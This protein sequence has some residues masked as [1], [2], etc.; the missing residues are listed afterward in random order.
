[1]GAKISFEE[2]QDYF[3]YNDK[4]YSVRRSGIY[5]NMWYIYQYAVYINSDLAYTFTIYKLIF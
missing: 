1:M 4:H 5:L 3:V 2:T